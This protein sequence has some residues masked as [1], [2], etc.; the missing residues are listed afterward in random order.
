[1]KVPYDRYV[2]V[3]QKGASEGMREL[4]DLLRTT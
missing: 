1:V 4:N 3:I 2:H